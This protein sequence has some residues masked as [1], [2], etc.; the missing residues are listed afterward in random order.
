MNRKIILM[1]VIVVTGLAVLMAGCGMNQ[2]AA[3]DEE[4]LVELT[5]SS[6]VAKTIEPDV[7]MEVATYDLY[8]GLA[9]GAL[10]PYPENPIQAEDTTKIY[11]MLSPGTY[12][13]TIEGFSADRGLYPEPIGEGS[14]FDVKISPR[15][16]KQVNIDV[17]LV[18]GKG[19]VDVTI[20][21]SEWKDDTGYDLEASFKAYV[22]AWSATDLSP[23]N[24]LFELIPDVDL[25]TG[26]AHLK[27][28][29]KDKGYYKCRIQMFEAGDLVKPIYSIV[30]ALRVVT[31][32]TAEEEIILDRQLDGLVTGVVVEEDLQ[33]PLELDSYIV[34][35]GSAV[36]YPSGTPLP[37]YFLL[38]N[39]TD[40]I[41][42]VSPKKDGA[43]TPV[44][45]FEWYIDEV[46][47]F[48]ANAGEDLGDASDPT[49]YS[50][51]V[52]GA[53]LDVG[54]H[55]ISA[56]VTKGTTVSSRRVQIIVQEPEL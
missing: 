43:A 2:Q 17:K 41:V 14:E 56:L 26:I 6:I 50:T 18:E 48:T 3:N 13:F 10:I 8:Y 47:P 36:D 54:F 23:N 24:A 55:T 5:I 9:D 12:D 33:N 38:A 37:D 7:V 35:N 20:N 40:I 32:Y 34:W 39:G 53:G 51:F 1:I 42:K 30:D 31:N 49:S 11:L 21:W 15:K 52:A 25:D 45:S 29:D 22:F 27:A 28:D 46:G 44:D 4:M 16:P 19:G